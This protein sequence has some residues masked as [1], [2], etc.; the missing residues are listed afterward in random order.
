MEYLQPFV[1]FIR[2][3]GVPTLLCGGMMLACVVLWSSTLLGFPGNWGIL[4]AAVLYDWLTTDAS[5][6]E[7]GTTLLITLGVLATVGEVVEFIAGALGV[8][9]R[10]GSRLSA[11][12]ALVGSILGGILGAIVAVPIP[13]VGPIIGILLGSSAGAMIGAT[14]GEDVRGRTPEE[15]IGVG[16]AAFW[17]RLAG[18]LGKTLIGA[19]MV[20]VVM[21][22]MLL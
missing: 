14:L 5:R 21:A 16:W 20:A 3:W 18:T 7:L 19:V 1:Q 12:L 9:K 15:S 2:D 17:G 10:G 22:G 13:I 11:T 4:L 6:R 8:R